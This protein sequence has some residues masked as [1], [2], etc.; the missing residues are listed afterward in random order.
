MEVEEHLDL[1]PIRGMDDIGIL[2]RPMLG[3]YTG[4][5]GKHRNL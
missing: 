2:V 5:K 3:G 4:D 1:S